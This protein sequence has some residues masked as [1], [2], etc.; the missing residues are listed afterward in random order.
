MK[1]QAFH[2]LFFKAK[3][4]AF[5]RVTEREFHDSQITLTDLETTI[6]LN[7]FGKPNIHVGNVGG[8]RTKALKDFLLYNTNQ[9]IQLNLVFPKPNKTELRLYLSKR[10]GFKPSSG[11]IWFI[12]INQ[13]NELIIGSLDDTLW[14]NLDQYDID[15]EDYSKQI[16]SALDPGQ[17]IITPLVESK[18]T[19]I[20]V[21]DRTTYKRNPNIAIMRFEKTAYT[22]EVDPSHKTFTSLKNNQPFVEAHH[23]IPMKFQSLF[24]HSLDNLHNIISLCPNCHRAFH[25]AIVEEKTPLISHIYHKR[26]KLHNR[27]SIE[28]IKGYYNCIPA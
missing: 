16:D 14:A 12:F 22:C 28:D 20:E 24:K 18:I 3:T 19:L 4:G 7:H 8:N 25:H 27:Y 2:N 9:S 21:K 5:S 11:M 6:I 10:N 17:K 13:N 1:F 26:P 23:F 15:D